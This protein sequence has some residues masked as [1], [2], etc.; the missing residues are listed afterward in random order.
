[1]EA[2]K[3]IFVYLNKAYIITIIIDP[4]IPK[5]DTSMEIEKNWLDIIYGEVK[6]EEILANTPE[7][8]GN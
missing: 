4:M 5:V 8:I 6:K 2:L 7:P 1:M 3:G